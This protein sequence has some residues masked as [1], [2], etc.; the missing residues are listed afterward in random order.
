[1]MYEQACNWDDTTESEDVMQKLSDP[2][3]RGWVRLMTTLPVQF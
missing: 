3:T 1:M 2:T